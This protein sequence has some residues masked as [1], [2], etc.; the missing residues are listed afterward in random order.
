MIKYVFIIKLI[1]GFI[2]M[3]YGILYMYKITYNLEY[4]S[5]SDKWFIIL[6]LSRDTL[7][8]IPF[9]NMSI[10]GW[11]LEEVFMKKM[12]VKKNSI[13]HPLKLKNVICIMSPFAPTFICTFQHGKK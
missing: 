8:V 9:L 3:K 5:C 4:F 12:Q 13:T 1:L 7:D 11:R 10:G 6:Y 2:Y